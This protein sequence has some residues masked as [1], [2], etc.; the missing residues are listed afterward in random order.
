MLIPCPQPSGLCV[1][2]S[3]AD[4]WAKALLLV[5]FGFGL[6]FIGD[7]VK[8]WEHPVVTSHGKWGP[9]ASTGSAGDPGVGDPGAAGVSGQ[10]V[11]VVRG[12]RRQ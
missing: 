10:R 6:F 2:G 11:R 1:P 12:E 3:R 8:A 9:G 4:A 7:G 5:L